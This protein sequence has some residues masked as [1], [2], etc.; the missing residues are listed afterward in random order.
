M[1]CASCAS[2]ISRI[3]RKENGVI[4]CDVNFA[5][6]QMTIEYD[7][8]KTSLDSINKQLRRLGYA[9]ILDA[10]DISSIEKN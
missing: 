6:Q 2:V 9:L 3:A 1:H 4:D 8:L 7:A 10:S 5:T